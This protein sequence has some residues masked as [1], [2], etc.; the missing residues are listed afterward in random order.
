MAYTDAGIGASWQ[1]LVARKRM[2]GLLQRG[3]WRSVQTQTL[4]DVSQVWSYIL[5]LPAQVAHVLVEAWSWLWWGWRIPIPRNLFWSVRDQP[6][7]NEL[8]QYILVWDVYLGTVLFSFLSEYHKLLLPIYSFPY[9]S[10][11]ERKKTRKYKIFLKKPGWHTLF[12]ENESFKWLWTLL[13]W[14]FMRDSKIVFLP[15][16]KIVLLR[17]RKMRKCKRGIGE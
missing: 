10:L 16:N 15:W 12:M 13:N 9:L 14:V 6:G 2:K 17:T 8:Q 4:G 11:K 7:F 3:D 1:E 5:L